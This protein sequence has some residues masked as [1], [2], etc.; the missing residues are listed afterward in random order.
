[1]NC[2]CISPCGFS[3]GSRNVRKFL[4]VSGEFFFFGWATLNSLWGQILFHTCIPL[5]VSR[6]SFTW[7]GALVIFVRLEIPQLG[8]LGKCVNKLCSPFDMLEGRGSR[9]G[10]HGKNVPPLPEAVDLVSTKCSVNSTN[11]SGKS[12]NRFTRCLLF[13]PITRC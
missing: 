13:T 2:Q 6:F 3:S 7:L 4:V 9:R 12:C 5:I 11:H 8:P 1:M 10:G